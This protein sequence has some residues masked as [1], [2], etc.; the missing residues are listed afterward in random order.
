VSVVH[1]ESTAITTGPVL[2]RTLTALLKKEKMMADGIAN[3]AERLATILE[4]AR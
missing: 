3:N 2:L 1:A 4:H